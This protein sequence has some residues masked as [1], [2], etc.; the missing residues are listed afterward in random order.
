MTEDLNALP[1]MDAEATAGMARQMVGE[2][3]F[4]KAVL[5]TAIDDAILATQEAVA[6]QAATMD[7]T[8]KMIHKL[9]H[10]ADEL[11]RLVSDKSRIIE[12]QEDEISSLHDSCAAKDRQIMSL[13][14]EY[15]QLANVCMTSERIHRET[16]QKLASEAEGWARLRLRAKEG[17]RYLA[18]NAALLA[19][20]THGGWWTRLVRVFFRTPVAPYTDHAVMR[21]QKSAKA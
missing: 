9:M 2:S 8:G 17:D 10:E 12:N 7:D 1:D 18:E 13:Y 19:E 16:L 5:G 15:K 6:Q 11:R 20:I 4:T 3:P 14:E 21:E